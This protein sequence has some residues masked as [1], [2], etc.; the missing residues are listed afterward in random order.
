MS[1]ST[2]GEEMAKRLKRAGKRPGQASVAVGCFV[3]FYA[4]K[5]LV[6]FDHSCGGLRKPSRGE[7][8]GG[9]PRGEESMF[10]GVVEEMSW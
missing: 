10:L 7:D 8:R 5:H 2:F 9:C 1:R 4:S 6:R 3:M